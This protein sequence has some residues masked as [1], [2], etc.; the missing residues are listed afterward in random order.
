VRVEQRQPIV[1]IV[2]RFDAVR[3][4]PIQ[5]SGER[6]DFKSSERMAA[7]RAVMIDHFCGQFRLTLD[8]NLDDCISNFERYVVPMSGDD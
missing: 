8:E 2:R 4:K 6:C 7:A 3:G 1:E 5:R